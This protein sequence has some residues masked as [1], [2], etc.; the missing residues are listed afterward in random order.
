MP[1]LAS[2]TALIIAVSF[3]QCCVNDVI[4]HGYRSSLANTD[5][6]RINYTVCTT[7]VIFRPSDMSLGFAET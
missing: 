1:A 6:D 3:T 2:V 4:A 5:D 7:A